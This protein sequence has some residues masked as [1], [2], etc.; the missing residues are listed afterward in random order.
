MYACTLVRMHARAHAYYG[1]KDVRTYLSTTVRMQ[2]LTIAQIVVISAFFVL[3]KNIFLFISLICF[4]FW[5][6]ITYTRFPKNHLFL[7]FEAKSSFF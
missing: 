1:T 5:A 2:N 7:F 4:I 3:C 6:H